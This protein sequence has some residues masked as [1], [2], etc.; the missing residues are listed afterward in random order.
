M[1]VSI[2]HFRRLLSAAALSLLYLHAQVPAAAAQQQSDE[3]VVRQAIQSVLELD[4]YR[5]VNRLPRITL[6]EALGDLT[7]IFAMRRPTMDDPQQ[8]VAS[9]TDDVFTILWATYN[10]ADA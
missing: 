1:G 9:A 10:S 6:D 5:G 2:G 3:A 4:T 7:I 8:V